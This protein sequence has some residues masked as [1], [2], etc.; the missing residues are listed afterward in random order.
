MNRID[1]IVL[2][3]GRSSR[4]GADKRIV[5]FEGES[6]VESACRRMAAAVDGRLITVTGRRAEAL[7]GTW[8]GIVC[9]DEVPDRGPLGGLAAGL[10]LAE[11]GAVVLAVDSP[12]VTVATLEQLASIGRNSGRVAAV[13]TVDRWEPLV[14][15]YPCS[16]LNDVRA[17][18]SQGKSAPHRLLEQWGAIAVT[19]VDPCELVNINTRDDLRTALGKE[20]E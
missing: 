12:L 14:A 4:F 20:P 15:F 17:A 2:A 6:L 13:R 7:P 1:G 3:G 5:E 9:A 19:S 10:A 11:F 8:R 18:L 16:V